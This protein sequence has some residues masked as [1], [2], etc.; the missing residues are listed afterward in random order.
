MATVR[1]EFEIA[2]DAAAV[3][4]VIGRFETGPIRM[5]PGFVVSCTPSEPG[6]RVVTFAS[7]TTVRERL[8]AVDE[9]HMRIVYSVI[10]DDV[11]PDHDNAVMQIVSL[12][13][14]RCRF[15]WLRDILP[16][17]LAEPFLASMR[18][19]G[20]NIRRTLERQPTELEHMFD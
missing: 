15:I 9:E 13:P 10:G 3:W 5:A 16:D 7:G 14:R 18:A 1:T 17:D 6:I 2:A 19:G 11:H 12:G 20:E 4:A 8:V